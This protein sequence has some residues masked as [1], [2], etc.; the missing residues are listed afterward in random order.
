M[1]RGVG[2]LF[3]SAAPASRKIGATMENLGHHGITD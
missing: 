1:V 2:G 3:R